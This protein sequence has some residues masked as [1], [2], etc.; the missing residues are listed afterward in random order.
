MKKII[1]AIIFTMM[2]SFVSFAGIEEIDAVINAEYKNSL[3]FEA[4]AYTYDSDGV[5]VLKFKNPV[6]VTAHYNDS[7]QTGRRGVVTID[8]IGLNNDGI[9]ILSCTVKDTSRAEMV[10]TGI[11][12]RYYTD[13][14]V[15]TDVKTG[16]ATLS[17]GETWSKTRI[18]FGRADFLDDFKK[19]NI[20][21]I[22]FWV[23]EKAEK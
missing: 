22:E 17:N 11:L 20:T 14:G 21:S 2:L 1:A 6:K 3:E 18:L 7:Y 16:L 19:K 13:D 12:V 9:P 15:Y 4:S 10:D 23:H 5:T 8:S